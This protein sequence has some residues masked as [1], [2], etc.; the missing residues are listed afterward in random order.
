MK[1][2]VQN[3]S[4]LNGSPL[5]SY[6]NAIVRQRC[7]PSKT[8]QKDG[9]P[10]P[11][12][13]KTSRR[14]F[15]T[16]ETEEEN[17]MLPS[18]KILFRNYRDHSH[19][20]SL[21]DSIIGTPNLHSISDF[22]FSENQYNSPGFK[23]RNLKLADVDKGLE[24]IGRGLA[25]DQRI[26]WREHWSFL[27]EFIDIS[28]NEGLTKFEKY[29]QNRWDERMKPPIITTLTQRKLQ[30]TP[31]PVTPVSKM[32]QKLTKLRIEKEQS[33]ESFNH[34]RASTPS[35]PSA[36][37]AYLCVEKSCQIY[38]NRLLKPIAQNPTNIV[39]VNDVLV[40]ELNRLK[41]LICSYKHDIRFFAVDFQATHSRFAH[42]VIALL[43]NELEYQEHKVGETLQSTLDHILHAKEKSAMNASKNGISQDDLAKNTTQLIC[44]IKQL[45]KRLDDSSNL[46][47]PEVLTT[48]TDCADIWHDEEKCDCEWTNTPNKQLNRSIKRKNRLSESFGDFCDRLNIR[49]EENETDEEE[50]TFWVCDYSEGFGKKMDFSMIFLFV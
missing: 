38:A 7:T 47:P 33:D 50:D 45:L 9:T 1:S 16:N 19:D 36:F 46:I 31:L 10:Q 4:P 41:S 26:T 17:V 11:S 35:S 15:D 2:P 37:H 43:N 44:L 6:P 27:D 22:S 25:K 5:S 34:A 18:K 28:S 3:Q 13:E 14:L 40:G 29:L 39:T 12:F 23:E 30:L 8:P 48:E 49:S 24:V 42:I 32:T 21:N 20:D